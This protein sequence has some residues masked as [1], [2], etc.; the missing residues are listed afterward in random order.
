MHLDKDTLSIE[1][2]IERIKNYLNSLYFVN[3]P[4]IDISCQLFAVLRKLVRMGSYTKKIKA[5]ER[6]SGFY[7]DVD[8]VSTFGL[9]CDA[10]FVDRV[11]QRWLLDL[12][13]NICERY[14]FSVYSAECWDEFHHFLDDIEENKPEDLDLFLGMVYPR[15]AISA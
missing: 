7:Y 10:I 9:Y 5:K 1:K 2:R 13:A 6:L 8:F 3:T 11:M 15:L 4:Y 12:D 14:A